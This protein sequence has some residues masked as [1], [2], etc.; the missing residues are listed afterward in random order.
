MEGGT[1][2]AASVSATDV[3]AQRRARRR[4]RIAP[5]RP[6]G[7]HPRMAFQIHQPGGQL[8]ALVKSIWSSSCD[9]PDTTLPGLIAPDAHVEFVF[10]LGTPCRM[11]RAGSSAWDALPQAMV[12]AQRHGCVRLRAVDRTEMVAFRTSAVTASAILGRSMSELWD[13]T[14]DLG[15]ILGRR[16]EELT[17]RLA[18][19]DAAGR[20]VLIETWLGAAL[21][22]WAAD[23]AL[24]ERMHDRFVWRS[25]GAPIR[26]SASEMGVTERSLRRWFGDAAGLSPK[27]LELSGRVLRACALLRE[28][29]DLSITAIAH[30]LGF[31]D[32]AAFANAFRALTGLTPAQLRVEPLVF[33]ER[34]NA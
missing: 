31:S 17:E 34:G 32:H 22:S 25:N 8:G 7:H 21:S 16:A 2:I 33:Y 18:A 24:L 13:R 30:E 23:E 3:Q 1:D 28:R 20:F 4:G 12:Y 10:Q 19:C 29:A 5:R 11:Q 26:V 14:V 15:A 27:Q 9:E 6:A